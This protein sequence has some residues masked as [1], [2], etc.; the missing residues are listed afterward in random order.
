MRPQFTLMISLFFHLHL[1]NT[2]SIF[3]VMISDLLLLTLQ[4]ILYTPMFVDEV[5]TLN[6][7]FKPGVDGLVSV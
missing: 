5:S 7:G 3:T 1:Y 2:K 6:R 4:G